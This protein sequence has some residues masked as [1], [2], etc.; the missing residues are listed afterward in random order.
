M[1]LFEPKIA[2]LRKTNHFVVKI[3]SHPNAEV[4]G[5]RDGKV[6]AD[7]IPQTHPLS[8]SVPATVSV[9]YTTKRNKEVC[10]EALSVATL[11]VSKPKP[12]ARH[13]L[14]S[15]NR[16]GEIVIYVRSVGDSA[17]VHKEDSRDDVFYVVK[18]EMCLLEAL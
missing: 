1:W 5:Q 11:G 16:M 8:R 10:R 15:G 13:V 18:S 2:E 14:I 3:E 7:P 12:K 6:L 4:S 9:E 17:Q